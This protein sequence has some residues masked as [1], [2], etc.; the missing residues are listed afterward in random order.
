MPGLEL[1]VNVADDIEILAGASEHDFLL[2]EFWTHCLCFQV[3]FFC[4]FIGGTSIRLDISGSN[5]IVVKADSAEEKK[6]CYSEEG[7]QY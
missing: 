2:S 5:L 7:D 3:L 1:G 6:A 4:D